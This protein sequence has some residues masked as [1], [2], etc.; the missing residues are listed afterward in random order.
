VLVQ[1][2]VKATVIPEILC[3]Y[4]PTHGLCP[5]YM[6]LARLTI[7]PGCAER[8]EHGPTLVDY[9]S[10]SCPGNIL[11]QRLYKPSRQSSYNANV[12]NA[13][14]QRAIWFRN[15]NNSLGIPFPVALNRCTHLPSILFGA[16]DMLPAVKKTIKL[17]VHVC[18]PPL[19]HCMQPER[20]Y[21]YQS[22]SS[23]SIRSGS[24]RR[25]GGLR[26]SRTSLGAARRFSTSY[27]RRRFVTPVCESRGPRPTLTPPQKRE[28]FVGSIQPEAVN[29]VG[30]VNVS[31]GAWQ[32]ILSSRD[33]TVPMSES[34]A[35]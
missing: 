19:H 15:T 30:C 29:L 10:T 12:T 2:L 22:W 5:L 33:D 18:L 16:Q 27:S 3:P 4:S 17:C 24:T 9:L 13:M 31:K 6:S 7:T 20:L 11:F 8:G 28:R 14:L 26:R 1:A 23:S 21:R 32:L 25:A 35:L 34:A